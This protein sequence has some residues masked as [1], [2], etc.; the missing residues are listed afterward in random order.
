MICWDALGY[1]YAEVHSWLG[2]AKNQVRH[3][4]K[5][6]LD[7]LARKVLPAFL[8]YYGV[9]LS[10]DELEYLSAEKIPEMDEFTEQYTSA[11]QIDS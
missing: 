8:S 9:E 1:A 3:I 6:G 4:S 10:F 11:I 2:E 5:A 7:F